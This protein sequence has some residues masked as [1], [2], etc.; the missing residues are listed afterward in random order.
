MYINSI[1]KVYQDDV[2]QQYIVQ[3][4]S[5]GSSFRL[6]GQITISASDANLS[7]ISEVV[8]ERLTEIVGGNWYE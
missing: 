6:D 1:T 8:Q 4:S 3:F 7:N 5:K 2:L